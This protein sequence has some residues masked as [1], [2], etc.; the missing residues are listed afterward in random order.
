MRGM[1]ATGWA[2]GRAGG[3]RSGQGVFIAAAAAAT[4]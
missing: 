2:E 1:D 4:R 3:D